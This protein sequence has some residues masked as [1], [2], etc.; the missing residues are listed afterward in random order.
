MGVPM[1]YNA[2]RAELKKD[3]YT[4]LSDQEAADLLNARS[5]PVIRE[6]P[7]QEIT[8]WAAQNGVMESLL[9]ARATNDPGTLLNAKVEKLLIVLERL[10][11]WRVMSDDGAPTRTAQSD[12][13]VLQ[14]AGILTAEQTAELLAMA[15]TTTSWSEQNGIGGLTAGDVQTARAKED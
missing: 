5:I 9:I 8:A 15:L 6:I 7:T 3:V 13:A 1:N 12:V 2:L 11:A 4:G 10:P 14:S